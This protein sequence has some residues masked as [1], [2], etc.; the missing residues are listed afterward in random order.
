MVLRRL[1]GS[2]SLFAGHLSQNLRVLLSLSLDPCFRKRPGP[3]RKGRIGDWAGLDQQGRARPTG[4]GGEWGL[5]GGDE[6]LGIGGIG[7]DGDGDGDGR[8]RRR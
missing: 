1:G 8:M 6:G 5:G 7:M 2:T 3:V 4:P